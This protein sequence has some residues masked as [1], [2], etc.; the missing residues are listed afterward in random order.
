MRAGGQKVFCFE[1]CTLDLKRGSLRT[2]NC[3]IEAQAEE[4]CPTALP[5]RKRRPFSAKGRVIKAVWPKVIVTDKLLARCVSDV[6]KALGDA[7]QRIVKTMTRRG[8]LFASPVTSHPVHV[9]EEGFNAPAAALPDKPSIAV[10]P[11]KNMSGDPEQEYFADGV[12]EEII[13]ALSRFR[14][15]FVIARDSS[16]TYKGRSADVKK[17]GRELGV[18]YVLEGSVR[19]A[20][21]KVRITGQLID[22]STRTHLW[23]NRFDGSLGD[24]FDLQD[25]VTASVVG[26]IAPKLEQA[27]IERAKRKPT[28][29]LD[30]YDFYLRG[31]ASLYQW[32]KESVSEALRLFYRAIELDPDFASAYG[33]AVRCYARRKADGWTT[34]RVRE[35]AEAERLARRAAEVG[36]DDAVALRLGGFGLAYVV[37]DLA[38]GAAM[39]DQ[40][41]VLNP[42][43]AV[44][45]SW[46]GWVRTFHGEPEVA[47]SQ[48]D[49]AMRLS[50]LDPHMFSMQCGTAFAHFLAGHYDETSSWAERSLGEQAAH[51][52]AL[53]ILAASSALAGRLEDAHAAIARL[54]QLEPA[55]RIS[56]L[57]DRIPL[58]GPHLATLAHGL[59]KAGLPE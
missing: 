29:S 53:R 33:M 3:D 11:F 41:L 19:K 47:I 44:A 8:Y 31:I 28:E 5:R 26:A 57:E 48:L 14:H 37:G 7:D 43:L 16:F 39:I 13:T 46:S 34:D 35:T 55:F 59:R 6:R 50:P 22:T 36:K 23:A 18:R 9:E 58:R 49:R 1:G 32:T 38:R 25:Q 52:P 45:W 4:L 17:I 10:L 21:N 30:A 54:R 56:D 24:I 20:A 51:S 27:E 15:I 42:N 2:E 40:A 12:V